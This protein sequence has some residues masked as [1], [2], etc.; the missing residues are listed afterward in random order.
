MTGDNKCTVSEDD[1]GSA[2]VILK[3]LYVMVEA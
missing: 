2:I 1:T 3:G